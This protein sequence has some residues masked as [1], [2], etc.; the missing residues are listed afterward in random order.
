[1]ICLAASDFGVLTYLDWGKGERGKGKAEK[2]NG[3]VDRG[4]VKAEKAVPKLFFNSAEIVK[5][6]RFSCFLR[7]DPILYEFDRV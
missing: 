3:D 7:V 6:D 2:G 5:S 4:K 1:M